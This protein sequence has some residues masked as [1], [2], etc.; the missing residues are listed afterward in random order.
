MQYELLRM[1]LISKE[2]LPEYFL[3]QFFFFFFV[4]KIIIILLVEYI[5]F[6]CH[7]IFLAHFKPSNSV[8]LLRDPRQY[9][10]Y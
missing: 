2:I 8:S 5:N 1:Q 3:T 9:F 7:V 4:E 6:L 10:S